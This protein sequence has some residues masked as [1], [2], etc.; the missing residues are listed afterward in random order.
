MISKRQY[1]V[2]GKLFYECLLLN[3]CILLV[4]AIRTPDLVNS[5]SDAGFR[6]NLLTLL[7]VFN[8]SWLIIILADGDPESHILGSFQERS[9]QVIRNGF[10]FIGIMSTLTIILK[11]E[12]FNRSSL[13]APIFLYTTCNLLLLKP[14]FEFM[15]RRTRYSRNNYNV[16]LV[17]NGE[18][19]EKISTFARQKAHLGFDLVGVVG[20]DSPNAYNRLGGLKDLDEIL[21]KKHIDE[22]FINLPQQREEDIKTAIKTA[23]MRGIRVNLVPETPLYLGTNYRSYA[24]GSAIPVYQLRNS[25]LDKFRNYLMKKAFDVV[26]AAGVM[27]I[28]SPFMLL[29]A[30]LIKIDSRGSILYAPIRKGEAGNTF[31]CLKFRTMS[32]CDDPLNGTKSTVKNDPRITRV[33]R[34]L[35]KYDLDELPQFINVLRGDMSVVGP[36]PHRVNLQNDFRKIVDEYMVRH[37]IKP[38]LTGWAQVNGWR[39]PTETV[40]QKTE[41]IRH[42]L[43]YI[44][45]WSFWIDI[46]I[47]FL[48]VFGRKSRINA[49]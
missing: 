37:Y 15:K 16:L 27:I 14:L 7:A 32:V 2:F 26:F 38:G 41:R 45:H 25:P 3:L 5:F 43:W 11:V 30:L 9:K 49:F 19:M 42:D 22:I 24:L 28:L 39:G 35:R 46:K 29:I 13:L 8:I 31:R 34:F 48:T 33:G 47:V 20:D 40:L 4:L 44:E 12:Y 17:G 36:R 10:I 18:G 1:L 21:D 23:D 6:E